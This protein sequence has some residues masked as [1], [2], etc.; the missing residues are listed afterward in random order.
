MARLSQWLLASAAATALVTGAAQAQE[1]ESSRFVMVTH[2]VPSDPLM[3]LIFLDLL[4]GIP[5]ALCLHLHLI[6]LIIPLQF[7]RYS[8]HALHSSV[9]S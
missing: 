6:I 7:S 4:P 8:L 2:G 3:P 9:L 5:A 1:Q